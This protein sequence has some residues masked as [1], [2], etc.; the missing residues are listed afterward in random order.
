MFCFKHFKERFFSFLTKKGKKLKQ[1]QKRKKHL[2][3]KYLQIQIVV[4]YMWSHQT[5]HFFG[6]TKAIVFVL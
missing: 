4:A 1:T 6:T 5:K 3:M 2:K